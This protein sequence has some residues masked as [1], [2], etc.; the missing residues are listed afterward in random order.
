M[1][2]CPGNF[3]H[4]SEIQS[5]QIDSLALND[6]QV[7]MFSILRD[8]A[9][10]TVWDKIL[11]L[12]HHSSKN[13][14][15]PT[16]L[17]ACIYCFAFCIQSFFCKCDS[18]EPSRSSVSVTELLRSP[19][20]P[21]IPLKPAPSPSFQDQAGFCFLLGSLAKALLLVFWAVNTIPI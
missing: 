10:D 15:N 7:P 4:Q 1:V 12:K 8:V 19:L 13:P 21:S 5:K 18:I 17:P 6:V 2:C 3:S 11:V 14:Q 9:H 20:Q 16:L